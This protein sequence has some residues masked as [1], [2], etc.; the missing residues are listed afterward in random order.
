MNKLE[1]LYYKVGSS[2][3]ISSSDLKVC[4]EVIK[5]SH[6]NNGSSSSGCVICRD[7]AP[8]LMMRELGGGKY[9]ILAELLGEII[10]CL[11]PSV[12]RESYMLG[13]M[14]RMEKENIGNSPEKKG[15][16]GV[17]LRLIANAIYKAYYSAPGL[18][19][20]HN[21]GAHF[22]FALIHQLFQLAIQCK[23]LFTSSPLH[24]QKLISAITP[25]IFHAHVPLPD[26]TQIQ[27]LIPLFATFSREEII[28]HQPQSDIFGTQ[29][30]I[31]IPTPKLLN[32][33]VDAEID[34]DVDVDI[35][36]D[37][38]PPKERG[39]NISNIFSINNRENVNCTIELC[40]ENVELSGG[41]MSED[42]V[43][44]KEFFSEI[45]VVSTHRA[46]T[47]L[48]KHAQGLQQ[49][50]QHAS[51]KEIIC[52]SSSDDEDKST[53]PPNS[54]FKTP[55]IQPQ[56]LNSSP[57]PS[58]FQI[59]EAKKGDS[60]GMNTTPYDNQHNTP[61]SHLPHTIQSKQPSFPNYEE[62][63]KEIYINGYNNYKGGGAPKGNILSKYHI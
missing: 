63:G 34:V 4:L 28:N 10:W 6:E 45:D 53:Q 2:E 7:V 35:D 30:H 18:P 40:S 15:S 32:L 56:P 47:S 11:P 25:I 42:E 22:P 12:V 14:L 49:I 20:L 59:I 13:F 21:W 19:S 29:D 43:D 48:N 41:F 62:E 16:F 51:N 33:D 26:Q 1:S 46:S 58:D 36:I 39:N 55:A 50:A 37:I 17:V 8:I 9:Y 61:Y 57:E 38:G 44:L 52:I 60:L 5:S 23:Q 24:T 31:P 27:K 3:K 54:T